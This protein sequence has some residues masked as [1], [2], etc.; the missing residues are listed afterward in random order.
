MLAPD[1]KKHP[2]G[3][4]AGAVCAP[5]V[6]VQTNGGAAAQVMGAASEP[7]TNALPFNGWRK[8]E[9]LLSLW[10]QLGRATRDARLSRGDIVVLYSIANRL[11]DSNVAWPGFERLAADTGIHRSTVVRSVERLENSGYL[12][13]ESGGIGKANRYRLLGSAEATGSTDATGS[14]DATEGVAPTRLGGVAPTLPESASLNLPIESAQE[15]QLPEPEGSSPSSADLGEGS[16]TANAVP[17]ITIPLKGGGEYVI[18]GAEVA[19]L[20]K[21]HPGKDVLGKLR[22]ARAWCVLN[23]ARRKTRSGV[24]KFIY[25]W[26]GR[27]FA[28]APPG[29]RNN[30]DTYFEGVSEKFENYNGPTVSLL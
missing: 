12:L 11:N 5:L 25:S 10:K 6:G 7:H 4:S 9:K 20:T 18:T 23:P 30:T 14:A 21:A 15:K 24:G 29:R 1:N 8:G 17:G 27:E 26:V 22:E 19:E 28:N 13:R 2:Q 3:E 16:V